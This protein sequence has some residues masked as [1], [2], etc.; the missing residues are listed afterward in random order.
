MDDEESRRFGLQPMA[1]EAET[2]ADSAG[3]P[4]LSKTNASR[5]TGDR[6][7]NDLEYVIGQMMGVLMQ[8]E[9]NSDDTEDLRKKIVHFL[10][11][12]GHHVNLQNVITLTKEFEEK[13]GRVDVEL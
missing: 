5:L 10:R 11:H 3:F 8:L 7:L 1:R 9:I 13:V 2:S 6:S 4:D 12:H